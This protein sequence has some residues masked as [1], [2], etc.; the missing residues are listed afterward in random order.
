MRA[1]PLLLALL[2][3]AGCTARAAD[4]SKLQVVAAERTWGGIAAQT[5]G[6]RVHVTDVIHRPGA[7]P[8]DYEP[9]PADARA[10]AQ[11]RMAIVNGAGYDPWAPKLLSANPDDGRVVLNVGKLVGVGD[12]GNPHRWYSP[13]DVQRV[14]D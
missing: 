2:V 9:T 12:G 14:I 7:D 4:R 5:G 6:E 11:S 13:A 10:T 8:H 3:V 1:L